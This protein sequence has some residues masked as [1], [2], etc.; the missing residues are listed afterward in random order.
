MKMRL[1][2]NSVFANGVSLEETDGVYSF[3]YYNSLMPSIQTGNEMNY[4]MI[5]GSMA[6][7]L[8]GVTTGVVILKRK[9]KKNN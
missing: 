4:P 5:L 1:V 8:I 7:S 6:I 9:N 3:V 2:L